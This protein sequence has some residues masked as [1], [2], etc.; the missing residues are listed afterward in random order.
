MTVVVEFRNFSFKYVGSKKWVLQDI[1][2][3]IEK[4][5]VVGIVGPTSAGKTTLLMALNGLIPHIYP[6][7]MEGD[8]IVY[9]MNTKHHEISELAQ[10]VGLVL[11]KPDTQ[12]FAPTV[13]EDV[14]FGPSNLGLS[15]EEIIHR[16]S[17][18]LDAVRLKGFENRNP[19]TLSGGEQQSLAIGGILAM[20]PK[21]MALDEPI[22]MLDPIGKRRVLSIIKKLAEERDLTVIISESGADIELITDIV[23]TIVV[24][25]GGKIVAIGD[26]KEVFRADLPYIK[27]SRP[28]LVELFVKLKEKFHQIEEIPFDIE[29]AAKILSHK[30]KK[31]SGLEE[32]VKKVLEL[33]EFMLSSRGPRSNPPLIE[34]ENV[35]YIYPSG[36]QALKG[37]TLSIHEGDVV[38]LIGQ[39]GSGKTTLAKLLVGLLKPSNKDA[40][41]FVN[42]L[43]IIKEPISK[44]IKV[45]NYVFQ[46]PDEQLFCETV[47][48]E[49]TF[50]LKQLG[51]PARVIENKASRTLELLGLTEYRNEFPGNL[52]VHLRKLVALASVLILEPKILIVDEPTTGLDPIQID[53]IVGMLVDLALKGSLKSLIIITHD[54]DT[55]AKYCNRVIVMHGGRIVLDGSPRDVFTKIDTLENISIAP[56]Q[57]VQLI[58]RLSD[59]KI[60]LPHVPLTV[61][62]AYTLFDELLSTL[63]FEKV[64]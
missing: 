15:R 34:V 1:N 36:V 21:I 9:G 41:I 42:G 47:W 7:I 51:Y 58:A 28:P 29:T 38:G 8:V 52:P 43:N 59:Y 48:K 46:N 39:N 53:R 6:G 61:E 22:S 45:I 33:K 50:G 27:G 5:S 49:V 30:L 2:I 60:L 31:G 18:A 57:I 40:K 32:K 3:K 14:V 11:Q 19:N 25:H 26:P 12:L 55:V 23:D 64:T 17:F 10:Y 16:A 20:L 35:Q 24:L 4:G 56:P 63:E 54:M 44:V 37:V 62:E 13:W